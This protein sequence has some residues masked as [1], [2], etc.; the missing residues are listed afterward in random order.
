MNNNR[1]SNVGKKWTAES[2]ED[3]S[4]EEFTKTK[5][6]EKKSIP[7]PSKDTKKRWEK[8]NKSNKQPDRNKKRMHTEDECFNCGLFGHHSNKCTS[9][10]NMYNSK[11]NNTKHDNNS[12]DGNFNKKVSEKKLRLQYLVKLGLT[13][14]EDTEECIRVAYKRL[15]RI[16]HPDKNSAPNATKQFQELNDAYIILT[17]LHD[18]Q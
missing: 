3:N 14:S 13:A 15:A 12:T 17:T 18:A 5:K 8:T 2:D 7:R 9:E 1:F 11:Q 16:I 4:D 6:E 10:P